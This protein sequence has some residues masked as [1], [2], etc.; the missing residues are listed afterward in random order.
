MRPVGSGVAVL[1]GLG[2][3]VVGGHPS[4]VCVLYKPG[5]G[6]DAGVAGERVGCVGGCVA[7][8]VRG[9]CVA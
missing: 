7:G 3:N 6:E 5:G 9:C 1:V 8:G 2:E 4:R